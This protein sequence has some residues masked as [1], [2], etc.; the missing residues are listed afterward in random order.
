VHATAPP[1]DLPSLENLREALDGWPTV[2]ADPEPLLSTGV[3]S[4]AWLDRA[5]PVLTEASA[6]C[7]LDGEAFVHL[8]VR[9][10]NLCIRGDRVVLVDWNHAAVGNGL[11]DAVAWAPSLRLEGGP[12]PWE[13]VPDSA[14]LATLLAGFFAARAGLPPPE[15]AP[16]VRE[17]QRR[18][19]E[20][21]LPW[22]AREL[23]L[24]APT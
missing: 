9:S 20:V 1:P 18:Q 15:T 4:S 17:F 19:L 16:T 21:A 2:V 24:A 11:I 10:D 6:T 23:G 13:L 7:Q 22:G 8:D 5:L 14:G 12:E 3:C